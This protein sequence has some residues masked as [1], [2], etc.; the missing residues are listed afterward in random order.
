MIANARK[1]Y[2]GKNQCTKNSFDQVEFQDF[3]DGSTFK[4]LL[5]YNTN[6]SQ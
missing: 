2:T 1:Y 4:N 5:M 3:K 6:M